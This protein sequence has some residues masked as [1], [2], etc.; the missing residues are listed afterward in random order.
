MSLSRHLPLIWVSNHESCPCAL[1]NFHSNP[2]N[3]MQLWLS[4]L[5]TTVI[6]IL[7]LSLS[8]NIDWYFSTTVEA[9][10][11]CDFSAH[12]YEF[13]SKRGLLRPPKTE[14]RFFFLSYTSKTHFVPVSIYSMSSYTWVDIF[15]YVCL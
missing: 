6:A 8:L 15:V 1:L 9:K 11:R 3:P 12:C 10:I 13:P 5:R 7:V 2:A 14:L 4:S